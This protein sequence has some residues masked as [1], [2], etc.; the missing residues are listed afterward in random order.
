MQTV[1][2][3]V[4]EQVVLT[5]AVASVIVVA[6][7]AAATLAANTPKSESSLPVVFAGLVFF[8]DLWA[9][10]TC[11][12][13]PQANRVVRCLTV[14]TSVTDGRAMPKKVTSMLRVSWC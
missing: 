14:G 2:F 1:T 10:P 7:A 5:S 13:S 12:S 3:H 4:A 11:W 9:L 6:A 8:C